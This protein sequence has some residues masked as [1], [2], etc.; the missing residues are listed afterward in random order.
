MTN[1]LQE[2]GNLGQSVW[3][4]NLTRELLQT[5]ELKRMVEQ[6]GVRGVTSNPT[7]FEKAISSEKIYDND[8][9]GLV[10]QG[11]KVEEIYENLVVADIRGGGRRSGRGL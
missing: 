6:D 9:H 1:P 10:D 7:I 8:L 2:I 3:Y 4:D 5:G 11:L